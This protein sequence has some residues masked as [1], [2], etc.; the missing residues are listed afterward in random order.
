[1]TSRLTYATPSADVLAGFA[2]DHHVDRRAPIQAS[3]EVIINAPPAQ[4]WAV[5]ADVR[6]WG[7][8]LEPGVTNVKLPQGVAVGAPFTRTNKGFTMTARFEVVVPERELAWTGSAVGV[9]VVHRFLLEPLDCGR[10]RVH[11]GESMG[12]RP[13]AILYSSAKLQEQM[14]ASLTSLAEACTR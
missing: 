3:G 2:R 12:G 10:T 4:V 11:C 8:S 7:A 9:R 1:M 13:L 14:D 6:G 5:L